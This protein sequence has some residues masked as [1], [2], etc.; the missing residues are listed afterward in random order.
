M[1]KLSQIG[2]AYDTFR[3]LYKEAYDS[4]KPAA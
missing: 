3:Q 1:G 4:N 2:F